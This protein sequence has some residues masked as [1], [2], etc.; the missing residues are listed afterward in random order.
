MINISYSAIGFNDYKDDLLAKAH[1][2]PAHS[3][4]EKLMIF[5]TIASLTVYLKYSLIKIKLDF[6]LKI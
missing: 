6:L 3:I 2:N 5:K 1:G 4:I